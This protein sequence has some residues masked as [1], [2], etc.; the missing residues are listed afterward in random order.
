MTTTQGDA[1]L[2]RACCDTWTNPLAR[3]LL[4][5]SLHPGGQ[6]ATEL[7][8]EALGLHPGARV[9]D[10]GCGY[11]STLRALTDRGYVAIGLDLAPEPARTASETGTVVIGDAERLPIRD[12]L[13]DGVLMECVMS[14]LP[15]KRAAMERAFHALKP[16]GRVAISDVTIKQPFPLPLDEVAAWSA[17][18]AGALT[19]SGYA[20]LLEEAGF[21][22]VETVSLDADLIG[23]I[24]QI[25]RRI[26][27]IQVAL[28][29]RH[30]DLAS[31][32]MNTDRL[33]G[34]R[35]LAALAGDVVRRGGA[36][37][38]LFHAARPSNRWAPR[39][40]RERL[41]V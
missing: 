30:V 19:A 11:G 40:S 9:L 20:S 22:E 7:A 26:S 2:K 8:I 18:V 10:V 27:L 34:V 5:E 41:P 23:V 17:C 25:R 1:A 12:G 15:D 38:R 24:D 37:Y 14:L 21:T 39:H 35:Q 6:R 33:E 4:G 3:L 16:G 32:G 28:T 29:A 36:G 13:F 31:V